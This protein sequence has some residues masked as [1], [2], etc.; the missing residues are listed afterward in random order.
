MVFILKLSHATTNGKKG[1]GRN[2]TTIN[3]CSTNH[4]TFNDGRFQTLRR[5]NSCLI[6]RKCRLSGET[7]C[8]S[9][10]TDSHYLNYKHQK[11]SV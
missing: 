7:E 4:I 5:S 1:F 11:P 6:K 3:T 2:T 9:K 10:R 8:I